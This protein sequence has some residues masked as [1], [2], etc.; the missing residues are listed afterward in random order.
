MKNNPFRSRF[1]SAKARAAVARYSNPFK[2]SA[3][4]VAAA[5]CMGQTIGGGGCSAAMVQPAP[6]LQPAY[7]QPQPAYQSYQSVPTQ[8]IASL[9][10]G[11]WQNTGRPDSPLGFIEI[12]PDLTCIFCSRASVAMRNPKGLAFDGSISLLSGSSFQ[13]K[14]NLNDSMAEFVMNSDGTFSISAISAR[15]ILWSDADNNIHTPD[16]NSRYVRSVWNDL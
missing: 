12:H 13:L 2:I 15:N 14:N 4:I 8:N 16:L 7:Q 5:L 9:I 1:V 3:V 11:T 10:V 6:Q